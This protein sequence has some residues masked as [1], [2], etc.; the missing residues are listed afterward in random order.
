MALGDAQVS[1]QHGDRLGAHRGAT[2]GMQGELASDDT[3]LITGRGNEFVRQCRRLAR[4]EHPSDYVATEH[5]KDDV[6][7]ET[8]PLRRPLELGDIPRPQFAGPL[9]E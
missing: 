8:G 5:I 2:V 1:Q 6:E 7:V 9:C 3:F 4:R